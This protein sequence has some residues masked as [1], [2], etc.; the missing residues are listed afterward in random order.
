MT[1]IRDW[2]TGPYRTVVID[3]PWSTGWCSG[4]GQH[5]RGHTSPPYPTLSLAE[6]AALPVP[7]L[8]A[9][10]ATVWLWTIQ[11]QLP[12]AYDLLAGWGLS[13]MYTHVW[14]KGVDC[15]P[16]APGYP[17][18]Q[19]EFIV[20]GRQGEFPVFRETKRFPALH[21]WPRPHRPDRPGRPLHAAKPPGFYELLQRVT[22]PPRIDLF[23]RRE[24]P[25]FDRWGDEAPA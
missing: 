11:R 22:P 17:R 18:Y 3:P 7:A 2:P 10:T 20:V 13:Y 14:D 25:G 4:R 16:Q 19:T 5:R 9:E 12:A 24:I 6:I 8:L 23:A 21:A 15:A 1:Q